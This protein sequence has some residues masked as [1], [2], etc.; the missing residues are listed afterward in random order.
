MNFGLIGYG[1]ESEYPSIHTTNGKLGLDQNT[2]VTFSNTPP[3][4]PR[5]TLGKTV[6]NVKY[7]LGKLKNLSAS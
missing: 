6:K 7:F 3:K 2:K 1:P 4:Q 5:S